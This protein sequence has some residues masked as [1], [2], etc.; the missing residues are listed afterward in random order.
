[1]SIETKIEQLAKLHESGMLTDDEYSAAKRKVIEES[2]TSVGRAANNFVKLAG[3]G[4]VLVL[5][6]ILA[7]FFMFFLPQW[8]N[9][10]SEANSI[11][12]EHADQFARDSEAFDRKFDEMRREIN[13]QSQFGQSKNP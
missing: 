5:A 7:F 10:K 8:N 3:L 13:G 11:Q 12:R 4:G 1:M 6:M 2:N 9:L